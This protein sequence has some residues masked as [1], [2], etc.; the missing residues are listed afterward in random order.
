MNPLAWLLGRRTVTVPCTVEIERTAES[1]HVHAVPEGI[2]LR[3]GD[4]V[5]VHG[6]PEDVAFGEVRS[7][8]TTATVTR[9]G[10]IER[11]WVQIRALF[12]IAE[13]YEVGFQPK[14]TP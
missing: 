8:E 14:E 13:L 4:S 3:P 5:V 7:F 2:Q 1:F 10:P 6:M 9:A 11:Q 12:E